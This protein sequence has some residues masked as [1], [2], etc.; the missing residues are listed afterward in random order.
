MEVRREPGLLME[1]SQV[2]ETHSILAKSD[3]L[4]I[5][6]ASHEE[7]SIKPLRQLVLAKWILIH[8]TSIH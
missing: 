2:S 6:V 3:R 4:Y 1:T 7:V 5:R 8:L